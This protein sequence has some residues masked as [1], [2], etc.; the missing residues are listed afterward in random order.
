VW[1]SMIFGWRWKASSLKLRNQWLQPCSNPASKPGQA[2]TMY[3]CVSSLWAFTRM[4]QMQRSSCIWS[5]FLLDNFISEMNENMRVYSLDVILAKR[6]RCINVE[7][8]F[9][10]R[11]GIKIVSG[12]VVQKLSNRNEQMLHPGSSWES[13]GH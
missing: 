2:S 13:L 1:R 10:C 3:I 12:K 9:T 8:S 5:F 7:F 11:K 6:Q 4:F